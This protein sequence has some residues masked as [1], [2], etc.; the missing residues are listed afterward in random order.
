MITRRHLRNN[1]VIV[2]NSEE[3]EMIDEEATQLEGV[4]IIERG[5]DLGEETD[6]Q[7]GQSTEGETE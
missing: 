2:D 3:G 5:G 1:R 4:T 6:M 7:G